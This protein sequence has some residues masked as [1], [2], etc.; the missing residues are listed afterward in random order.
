M[1]CLCQ[2]CDTCAFICCY[3]VLGRGHL[4]PQPEP[5]TYPVEEPYRLPPHMAHRPHMHIYLR[6][7]RIETT[8]IVLYRQSYTQ[9]GFDP[10]AL[11]ATEL[12]Q[13]SS[14]WLPATSLP[15]VL[16]SLE[17]HP[18]CCTSRCAHRSWSMSQRQH[19]SEPTRKQRSNKR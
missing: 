9:A 15:V 12:R 19:K 1:L 5:G 8:A 3:F 14:R 17:L 4:L 18:I 11:Y 10:A 16:L 6:H 7:I 13:L 2:C